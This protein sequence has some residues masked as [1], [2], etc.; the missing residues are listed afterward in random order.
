MTFIN[1]IPLGIWSAMLLHCLQLFHTADNL[2]SS[3]KASQRFSVPVVIQAQN[4]TRLIFS[5]NSFSEG[6]DIGQK[7]FNLK[8]SALKIRLIKYVYPRLI[9]K[10]WSTSSGIHSSILGVRS[11][12]QKMEGLQPDHRRPGGP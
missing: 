5:V 6:T 11:P 10:F 9:E 2:T 7:R 4:R 3:R 1:P 12:V 8:V